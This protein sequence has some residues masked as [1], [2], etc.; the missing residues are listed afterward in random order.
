MS[1]LVLKKK[2]NCRKSSHETNVITLQ[3]QGADDML[4]FRDQKSSKPVVGWRIN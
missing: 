4:E 3:L 2:K 1:I